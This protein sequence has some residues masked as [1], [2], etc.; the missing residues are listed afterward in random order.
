[1]I[2]L[3]AGHDVH[4]PGAQNPEYGL[5]EHHEAAR[6]CD[7]VMQRLGVAEDVRLLDMGDVACTYKTRHDSLKKKVKRINDMGGV[8]LAIDLHFNASSSRLGHGA[9]TLYYDQ[10]SPGRTYAECFAGPLEEFDGK[11]DGRAPLQHSS[12]LYFLKHTR[13]PALVLEPL[14]ID[15]ER[16]IGP[17]L[18]IYGRNR[19]ADAVAAG[20]TA[21]RDVE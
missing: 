1:M 5:S 7:L 15:N 13:C 21:A 11:F 3:T 19:L 6:I 4:F 8:R 17:L 14:F 18:T 12:T 2:I 16:D 9:E 20:I 10:S